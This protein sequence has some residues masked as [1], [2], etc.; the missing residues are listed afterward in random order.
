MQPPAWQIEVGAGP[1]VAAANHDGHFV[2]PELVGLF[3][4]DDAARLREEDPFTAVWTQVANTRIVGR[5]S[6]FEVDLNRPRDKAVYLTPADAWGLQVW[7]ETPPAEVIER[8][9]AIYDAFYAAVEQLLQTAVDR[10]GRVVVFDLHSYNHRRLGPDGPPA[11]VG[12]DPEVNLGTGTMPDRARWAP[13]I[14]RFIADL[15]A[16]DF[17]GRSLDV[18][19]NVKFRGGHFPRRI[20]EAF[21]GSVCVLSIELKKFFMDEWSGRP[22]PPIIEAIGR[23]LQSTVHGV[24]EELQKL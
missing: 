17:L 9:L 5:R 15:R 20:H 6:R 24:Q 12:T 3:A 13:I 4:L 8:S 16:F 18:R 2:R 19:E 11:D 14:D 1:L 22:D 23:A 10:Y 7:T 21:P